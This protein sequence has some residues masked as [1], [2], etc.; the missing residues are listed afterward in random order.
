MTDV[1]D[2]PS[3]ADGQPGRK[4]KRE[5]FSTM[6]VGNS[7]GR[8][9]Q[10]LTPTIGRPWATRQMGSPRPVT[11]ESVAPAA[12]AAPSREVTTAP[13][14]SAAEVDPASANAT[15]PLPVRMLRAAPHL[16]AA[17][18]GKSPEARTEML[19]VVPRT[20]PTPVQH[21]TLAPAKPTF[22]PHPAF[23]PKPTFTPTPVSP[24]EAASPPKAPPRP[25][26]PNDS[27]LPVPPGDHEKFRYVRSNAWI[28][29]LF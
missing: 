5:S 9:A 15:Q 25:A 18:P 27:V 10:A 3:G 6:T 13:C 23:T 11:P 7:S 28:L 17:G 26:A 24:P 20:A 19:R 2:E 8:D 12:E 14:D 1:I 29:T 4:D 16:Q 21:E 22:T